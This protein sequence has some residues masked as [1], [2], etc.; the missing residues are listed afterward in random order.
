MAKSKGKRPRIYGQ[1]LQGVAADQALEDLAEW[2]DGFED[3]VE[4]AAPAVARGLSEELAT[5]IEAGSDAY[6]KA[7]TRTADGRIPLRG[8]LSAVR[9]IVSGAVVAVQLTGIE[10]AHHL[11]FA[12]GYGGGSKMRRPVIPEKRGGLPQKWKERIRKELREALG[13]Q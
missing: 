6:G 4:A 3:Q 2:L 10:V 11:G 8:A 9:W 5:T 13:L 7:W 1:S 12:R